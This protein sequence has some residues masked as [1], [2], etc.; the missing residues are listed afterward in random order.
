M[1]GEPRQLSISGT[2]STPDIQA[3]WDTGTLIMRGDSY[4]ENTFEIFE[5]V[6]CWVESFLATASIPLRVELY[7]V[8]LNTSSIRAMIDIL[9]ALETAHGQ[10]KPV[11]LKW[12]YD[13]RNQR[14]SELAEEFKEDYTFPFDILALGE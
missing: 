10:G 9:D 8:Y 6:I 14:V 7:L 3:D 11:G 13:I 1:N 2:L 12:F 4:P 5:Q